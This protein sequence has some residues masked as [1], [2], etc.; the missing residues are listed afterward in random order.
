MTEVTRSIYEHQ[1]ARLEKE[2]F[3]DQVVLSMPVYSS[4]NPS[5]ARGHF[6]FENA[7]YLL[8]V[9]RHLKKHGLVEL[10]HD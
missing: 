8:A 1:M 10:R 7:Q 2:R 3:F 5:P 4:F 9:M 6:Q